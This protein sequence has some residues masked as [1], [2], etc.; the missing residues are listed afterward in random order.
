MSPESAPLTR[1][2][3]ASPLL[4]RALIFQGRSRQNRARTERTRFQV[5]AALPAS[6][7][8][9][10]VFS[11]P[12]APC[13]ALR[14]IDPATTAAGRTARPGRLTD[15][16]PNAARFDQAVRARLT[17]RSAENPASPREQSWQHG[18]LSERP[19]RSPHSYRPLCGTLP[20]PLT[21]RTAWVPAT[22]AA[23]R[24]QS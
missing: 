17:C 11:R 5:A 4:D 1:M 19:E 12:D 20:S 22:V 9:T 10:L 3:H 13:D 18:P 8:R 15:P 23:R 2:A 7:S 14:R 24:V 6:R 21:D 16:S